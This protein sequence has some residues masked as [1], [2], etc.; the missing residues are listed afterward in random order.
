MTIKFTYNQIIDLLPAYALGALE[1]E[2][3]LAV[4]TYLHEHQGLVAQLQIAEEAATQLAYVAPLASLPAQVK[5]QLI[6]RI[7]ADLVGPGVSEQPLEVAEPTQTAPLRP[8]LPNTVRGL[9]WLDQIRLAFGPLNSWAAGFALVALVLL[10]IYVGQ[11]RNRLNQITSRMAEV[12]TELAELETIN[13][14]L[15]QTNEMLEQ[16]L[17]ANQNQLALIAHTD[18][19]QIVQVPGTAEAP[20]ARGILYVSGE[21]GVLM[22]QGLSPL[23]NQ[24]TYQLWLAPI[25]EGALSAG[26]LSISPEETN[27]LNVNIPPGVQDLSAVGVSIEPAGG[28]PAPTGPIVLHWP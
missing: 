4:D 21:R 3:L 7:Q 25:G 15:Q 23:P 14:G 27:W 13:T 24:Q 6:A 11:L 16:Q 5:P 22:L 26:L 12:Q 19:D 17:Q 9:T 10:G 18:F 20:D 2:E 28:S 1:P 8:H